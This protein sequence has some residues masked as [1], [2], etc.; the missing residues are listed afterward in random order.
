M[1]LL[2]E[3]RRAVFAETRNIRNWAAQQRLAMAAG[4]ATKLAIAGLPDALRAR[5]D[6]ILT[7]TADSDLVDSIR[8]DARGAA[9]DVVSLIGAMRTAGAAV[10][11]AVVAAV[12]TQTGN[13]LAVLQ[14]SAGGAL[15][16]PTLAPAETTAL[17][18]ALSGLEA[19]CSALL[20][21][22]E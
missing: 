9:I 2:S 16:F 13:Y 7:V 21:E 11:A 19:A 12:P 15:T 14:R 20:N 1:P 5:A 18:D 22:V 10:I 6:T 8:A 4:P 3:Q 17:R